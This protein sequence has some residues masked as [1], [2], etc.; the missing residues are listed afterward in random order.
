M[1]ETTAQLELD[2]RLPA[3]NR[4]QRLNQRL[5]ATR[6]LAL[7]FR[8]TFHHIDRAV[9]RHRPGHTVSAAIAGLP[10]IL[11]TTTGARSGQPRTVPLVAVP[12]PGGIAVIA[13]RFGAQTNPAWYYNLLADHRA[14]VEI[15]DRRVV[16]EAHEVPDGE[17]Y[18]EI[19]RHADQVYAG[20]RAY[21]ARV[22]RRHIPVFV[23]R[24]A[25]A[26]DP[27]LT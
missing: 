4:V 1:S 19:M 14:V 11:L 12:V 26:G 17:A 10:N 23:L 3:A 8:H 20:F 21:R 5:A 7:V 15:A 9:A 6:A 25:S 22:T 16:V 2:V 24:A 13:T 27:R 18:D